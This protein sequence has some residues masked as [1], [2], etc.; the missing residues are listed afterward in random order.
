MPPVLLGLL[1]VM[2]ASV[3][4][5]V[6]PVLIFVSRVLATSIST[7]VLAVLVLMTALVVMAATAR[8]FPLLHGW[9]LHYSGSEIIGLCGHFVALN[10]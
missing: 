8:L 9:L 5:L 1:F 3:L 4:A 10:C 2:F 7:V 6:R